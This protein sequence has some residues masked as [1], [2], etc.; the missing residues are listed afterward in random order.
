MV[1]W[2]LN[3]RRE[4]VRAF[5]DAV[6]AV[7]Q[8]LMFC[9]VCNNFA[10]S[11]TCDI[12][13]DP[14]RD[15]ACICVV[16]NPKDVAALERTGSYRG[17]YHVLLGAINPA[18][19]RG[20]ED[21][22]IGQLL[23]RVRQDGVKEVVIATDADNDGEMTA[24]YLTKHL[25]PLG[26]KISRIGVGLPVGGALEYADLSTLSMSMTGRREITD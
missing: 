16:E 3:Q 21:L 24:L 2:L 8:N 26:V 4:D 25:K 7:R 18:E 22:K 15:R 14:G 20:P 1:F 10:D 9:E 23:D 13:S 5:S 19:G 11:R 6:L 17:L 12:C